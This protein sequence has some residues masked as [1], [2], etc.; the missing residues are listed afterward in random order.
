MQA[1]GS[2]GRVCQVLSRGASGHWTKQSSRGTPESSCPRKH[3]R[4]ASQGPDGQLGPGRQELRRTR[5]CQR[6]PGCLGN[7]GFQT[8]PR[9][10]PRQQQAGLT[11]C[12]PAAQGRKEINLLAQT[13]LWA[14]APVLPELCPAS[15]SPDLSV[16]WTGDP[17][18]WREW[19]SRE[20]TGG[21]PH[22]SPVQGQGSGFRSGSATCQLC[23][24]RPFA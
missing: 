24:P 7:R 16:E 12:N 8:P 19:A 18:P 14:P 21:L 17:F 6:W 3:G 1:C 5:R 20:R 9:G 4:K 15:G 23:D 13:V 11:S 10:I 2:D 22:P